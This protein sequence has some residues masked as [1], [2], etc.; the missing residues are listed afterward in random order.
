MLE[1]HGL[2]A[3]IVAPSPDLTYLM[4][5]GP[6]PLERATLLTLVPGAASRL[7]VPML[8]R[9]LALEAPGAGEV[10]IVGWR[11]GEDPYAIVNGWLPAGG[12]SRSGSELG[13]APACAANPDASASWTSARPVVGALRARKD[14]AELD[15]LG[16]AAEAA[17]A[18]LH[19]LLTRPLA[20]RQERAIA[21][22]LAEML[23]EHGHDQ[24][25][26]TIVAS[27]PNPRPRR[28]TSR[29]SASS[30][31]ETRSCWTSAASSTVT[32][33]TD[34]DPRD[35]DGAADLIEVY[36]VVFEAQSEQPP[37][38]VR[39]SGSATWITPRGP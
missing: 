22:E 16:R 19:D 3:L 21:A 26:F 34:P 9:P 28:I 17:D 35:R 4:D 27:G 32:A 7:L 31:T 24:V 29:P 25:D 5:Y 30:R 2:D 33:A 8:E 20:G 39:G 1:E 18:T 10:E 14:A 23:L 12:R 13:L 37:R 38:C 36:A 6:M 15:A 11:D